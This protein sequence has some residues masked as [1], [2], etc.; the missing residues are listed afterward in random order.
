MQLASTSPCGF[1]AVRTFTYKLEEKEK[2]ENR[3]TKFTNGQS[4]Q[5]ALKL[6]II[7]VIPSNSVRVQKN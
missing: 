2:K 3:R 5:R 1:N 7:I 4:F 6:V